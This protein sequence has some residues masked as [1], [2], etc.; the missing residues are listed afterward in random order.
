MITQL[1][2]RYAGWR[3]AAER[4]AKKRWLELKGDVK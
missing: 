4:S 1:Q 2:E 3:S